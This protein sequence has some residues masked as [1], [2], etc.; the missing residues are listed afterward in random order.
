[1]RIVLDKFDN[2]TEHFNLLV[3]E[4]VENLKKYDADQKKFRESLSTVDSLSK[5][6]G[7]QTAAKDSS[8]KFSDSKLK[9]I[10]NEA[11]I[12]LYR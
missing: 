12:I 4:L 7:I 5:M 2:Q 6:Q 8:F 3:E 10:L 9:F 1:M 11:N